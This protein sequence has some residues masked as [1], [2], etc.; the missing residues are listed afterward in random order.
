MKGDYKKMS[1]TKHYENKMV[2]TMIFIKLYKENYQFPF[3]FCELTVYEMLKN[4]SE[5]ERKRQF[6]NIDKFVKASGSIPYLSTKNNIFD[7]R[8]FD[9]RYKET[10]ELCQKCSFTIA[11]FSLDFLSFIVELLFIK[12]YINIL[13]DDNKSFFERICYTIAIVKQKICNDNKNLLIDAFFNYSKYEL[14]NFLITMIN[15]YIRKINEFYNG[16]NFHLDEIDGL[17]TN[18]IC[19]KN[20]IKFQEKDIDCFVENIVE[21]KNNTEVTKDFFKVYLKRLLLKS[22][23]FEVNDIVD[24]NIV[25]A[26]ISNG[27]EFI[28]DESSIFTT[29]LDKL[30]S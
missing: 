19:V 8:S 2:D 27:I 21:V 26:A 11:S 5:E 4:K 3:C 10:I 16:D 28:S 9:I 12:K 14:N 24:M 13:N 15:I 20:K 30:K 17:N 25:F 1:I 29:I 7:C 22:G 18:G 23:K 6:K